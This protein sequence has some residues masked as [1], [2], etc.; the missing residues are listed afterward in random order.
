MNP[1]FKPLAN[2]FETISLNKPE[3][4]EPQL[5]S[6]L[7]VQQIQNDDWRLVL[8]AINSGSWAVLLVGGIAFW[9]LKQ[10]MSK[11]FDHAIGLL[12]ALKANLDSNTQTLN[13]ITRET[14]LLS[15][16]I[17]SI[18]CKLDKNEMTLKELQDAV[19]FFHQEC[20][21]IQMILASRNQDNYDPNR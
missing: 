21:R 4:V 8:D 1:L 2:G 16:A 5:F 19:Q 7:T 6:T 12:D 11:A 15:D 14:L 20:V 10:P 9:Y 3:D 18:G 13:T 17:R